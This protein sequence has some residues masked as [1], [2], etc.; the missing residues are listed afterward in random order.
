[1]N[2]CFLF[3]VQSPEFPADL[4]SSVSVSFLA[5]IPDFLVAQTLHVFSLEKGSLNSIIITSW[6]VDVAASWQSTKVS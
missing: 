1:M 4:L 2:I 6:L 5:N 3:V